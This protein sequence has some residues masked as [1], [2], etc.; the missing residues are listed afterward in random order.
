ML[1]L[2]HSPATPSSLASETPESTMPDS[3]EPAASSLPASG[4]GDAASGR[5][6]VAAS[7]GGEVAASGRREVVA[8][9]GGEVAASGRREVAASGG[10]EV[11]A[12]PP[13]AVIGCTLVVHPAASAS[14]L[15]IA[16]GMS[17]NFM[18]VLI[19]SPRGGFAIP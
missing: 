13:E 17:G 18:C 7:G 2:P 6:E 10:G 12:S 1:L 3:V 14:T 9:G 16:I 19:S 15:A 11:A 8:S 4:R 5:E